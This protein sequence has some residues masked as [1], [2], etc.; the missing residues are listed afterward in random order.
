MT[1]NKRNRLAR[2]AQKGATL[3]MVAISLVVLLGIC[4]VAIDLVSLYVGRSEAQRAADAAALAGATVFVTS[5][6]TSGP[7]GCV[8]G[9]PQE[10]P[11]RQKAID[12][13]SRNPVGGQAPTILS[14]DVTFAYPTPQDPNIIVRV[15][16]D[17]SHGGPM[18]TFFMKIFGVTSANISAAATAEA[19]NPSGSNIPVGTK[20]L[21]PWL[22][23]N[24]DWTRMVP[25]SNPNY[26]PN[27]QDAT[28]GL[29]A[30]KFVKN[31]SIVNPGPIPTGVIGQLMTIKPGSPSQASAPSKFYPVFL[32]PG[33][34][35]S[36]CPSCSTGGAGGGVPSGALYRQN[37]ECCNQNT[38]TC[39]QQTIQPITGNMVGP[40]AQGVDCLIHESNGTGQDTISFS[41]TSSTFTA[42]ANNP[43]VTAGIIAAGSTPIYP[44]DSAVTV[45]IYDG[46][47]LCPGLG[48]CGAVSVNVIG[49]M[50]IFVKEETNPQGT[51]NVYV[52]NVAACG[53]SSGGGSTP[54]IITGGGSP[55]PVRLIRQ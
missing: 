44:S 2:D 53:T 32:P 49:F 8:A 50:Q 10:A 43:M 34:V 9:G 18:P 28:T 1:A 11:A 54:P 45:P 15:A 3:L 37:I 29:Y 26:N 36:L 51:V 55:I 52:M 46:Q 48:G 30:T 42:G 25:S 35:A 7:L 22:M 6:C 27:C 23:P 5:G 47:V 39:G 24:C 31:N 20:C 40:T 19:F 16:R 41:G 38:I 14:T 13:G 12:V 21:K 17:A 33:S 4:A